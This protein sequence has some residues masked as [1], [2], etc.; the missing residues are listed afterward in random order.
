MATLEDIAKAL[1]VSK[2][3][4]SKALNGA[5]DVSSTMRNAVLEK[6][7]ELGYTRSIR[8]EN[9][10]K[11]ALFITNMEYARPDD[12]GYDLVAGV[13]KAAEPAGFQVDLIPLTI[14]MQHPY[15]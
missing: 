13:R 12:F 14:Q 15:R 9:G 11:I 2:G 5:K 7:V 8:R 1:G 6:A 10:Q 4:V 3:T